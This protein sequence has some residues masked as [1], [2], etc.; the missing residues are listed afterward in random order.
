MFAGMV[1]TAALF[2]AEVGGRAVG[3][4]VLE[5]RGADVADAMGAALGAVTATELGVFTTRVGAVSSA[6]ELLLAGPAPC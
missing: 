4:G 3:S 2:G 1:G 6:V 5:G